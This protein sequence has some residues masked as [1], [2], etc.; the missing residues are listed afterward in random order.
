MPD[1]SNELLIQKRAVA[2]GLRIR[3]RPVGS[4]CG[5]TQD[6]C[7]AN[8]RGRFIRR[9]LPEPFEFGRG[10]PGLSDPALV[11]RLV[12]RKGQR[13]Q[14]RAYHEQEVIHSMKNGGVQYYRGEGHDT[15]GATRIFAGGDADEYW[16]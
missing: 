16:R 13:H 15:T 2:K 14:E 10:S 7:P 4:G 6:E 3:Q 8:G 11:N 12:D 1:D 9:G 5:V